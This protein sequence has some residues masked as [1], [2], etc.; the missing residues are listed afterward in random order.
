MALHTDIPTRAQVDR[1]LAA[2]NPAACRSTPRGR[3]LAVRR[4]DIRGN[5]PVAAILRYASP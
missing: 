2:R 4:D 1:L 3:V 5:Q